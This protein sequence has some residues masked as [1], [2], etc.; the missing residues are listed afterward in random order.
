MT[1]GYVSRVTHICC[2]CADRNSKLCVKYVK[3]KENNVCEIQAIERVH[4]INNLP[5][6]RHLAGP[7]Y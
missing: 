6:A 4:V 1:N 2:Y 7:L 5:E 3:K